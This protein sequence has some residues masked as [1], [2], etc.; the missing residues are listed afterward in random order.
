M[1]R[2]GSLQRAAAAALL[3]AIV[4]GGCGSSSKSGSSGSTTTSAASAAS[5]TTT[6]ASPV[7]TSLNSLKSSIAT[8][9]NPSTLTGGKSSIQTALD[10]VKQSVSNL[11]STASSGDKPKVD[12]VT[13]SIDE[14]Q[15]AVN[16]VSGVSGLSDV[17]IAIGNVGTSVQALVNAVK[18]GCPS[19]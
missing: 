13:S 18:A 9:T 14:L 1:T 3:T 16:N 4:L 7:C 2:Q 19:S 6:A 11:K 5:G 10:G 15:K 17:A 8:L 12:A